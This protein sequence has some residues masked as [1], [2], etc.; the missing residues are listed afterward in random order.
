MTD[1]PGTF[2]ADLHA[3]AAYAHTA[4]AYSHGTGDHATAQQLARMA[5][6]E[7]A[8]AVRY[9]DEL[10]QHEPQLVEG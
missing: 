1:G 5:L 6:S 10:E 2:L 9:V 4:A 7:S 8:E 3:K